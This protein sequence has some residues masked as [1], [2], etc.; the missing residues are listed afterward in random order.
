MNLIN[1]LIFFSATSLSLT[2]VVTSFS[3]VIRVIGAINNVN[4]K[5]WNLASAITMLNSFFIALSLSSIAFILD[6][7]PNLFSISILFFLSTFLVIVGHFFILFYFNK[8]HK[9]VQWLSF[10]YFKNVYIKDENIDKLKFF[11]F[12]LVTFVAWICFLLGFIFPSILA[13][14]FNEYRTTLF[15]LSFVF[16]SIG[17]FLTIVITDKK[18]SLLS[19][20][21]NLNEKEKAT[22]L[23]Y[24]SIVLLNRLIASL[25]IL[26]L[27]II[28][29]IIGLS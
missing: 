10:Q 6:N 18:A 20:N 14:I 22:I 12:D 13:I 2:Y 26:I 23:N 4:A 9:L 19:D 5:S 7:R 16:N 25:A 24:L 28:F 27:L 21:E 1:F 15:Q 11:K 3:F 17:T 8:T 29:Y